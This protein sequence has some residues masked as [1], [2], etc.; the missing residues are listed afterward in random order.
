MGV[1]Q[2]TAR[3]R[4]WQRGRVCSGL[5]AD[6]GDDTLPDGFFVGP[7]G[8]IACFEHARAF[9]IR[10]RFAMP[11]QLR[12]CEPKRAPSGWFLRAEPNRNGEL[13]QRFV[14]SPEP[15]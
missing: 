13:A 11:A 3:S 14:P 5:R 10:Y 15:L 4:T 7:V 9:P 2:S 6:E 8:E 1:T 12:C